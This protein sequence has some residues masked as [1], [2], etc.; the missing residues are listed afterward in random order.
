MSE[1]LWPVVLLLFLSA[2][3]DATFEQKF[4]HPRNRAY[5]PFFF[6]N[7]DPPTA[8]D[9]LLA[10]E[11]SVYRPMAGL[12]LAEEAD[13]QEAQSAGLVP[14][15]RLPV[16]CSFRDRFDRD[17][18]LAYNFSD[19]Q[20]RLSLHMDMGNVGFGGVEVD[21]VMVKFRY[22]FQDGESSRKERCR[23]PSGF[24]GLIGSGYNEFFLRQNDTVWDALRDTNPLGLFD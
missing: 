22:K 18:A 11:D 24:Q 21:K 23:Y 8:G 1:R 2:C 15:M 12:N 13:Q 7:N 14:G 20:T 10:E 3:A 6:I 4:D 16:G 9:R 5:A 19:R 17:G